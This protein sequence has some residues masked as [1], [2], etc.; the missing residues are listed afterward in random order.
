MGVA[1]GN[2]PAYRVIGSEAYLCGTSQRRTSADARKE[3]YGLRIA[4]LRLHNTSKRKQTVD[5][6]VASLF[7]SNNQFASDILQSG[8][9]TWSQQVIHAIFEL[10]VNIQ[11]GADVCLKRNIFPLVQSLPDDLVFVPSTPE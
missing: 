11:T 4:D 6:P 7:D 9:M 5:L 2:R 8:I 10:V 3:A 1:P